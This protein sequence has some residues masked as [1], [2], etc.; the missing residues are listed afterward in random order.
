MSFPLSRV[1]AVLGCCMVAYAQPAAPPSG[2]I[3]GIVVDS[4]SNAPIRRA[5]VTLSTVEALPRDAVAWTDAASHLAICRRAAMSCASRRTATSQRST[6]RKR[7]A[8]RPTR[9][10]LR[11]ARCVAISFS[12]YSW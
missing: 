1:L 5:V 12:A 3:A 8:A 9:F 4:G 2:T 6:A 7:R 11:P 10:N